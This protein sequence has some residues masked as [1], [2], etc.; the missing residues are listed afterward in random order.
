MPPASLI[1]PWQQNH[2]EEAERRIAACAAAREQ[3]LD[4]SPLELPFLPESIRALRWLIELQISSSQ[5]TELPAWFG[6]LSIL[7]TLGMEGCPVIDLPHGFNQSNSLRTIF[8][9][10]ESTW[11]LPRDATKK[12]ASVANIICNASKGRL[13]AWIRNHSNLIAFTI[14]GFEGALPHW[15]GEISNLERLSCTHGDLHSL[16]DSILQLKKLRSL[17]LSYNPRLGIPDELIKSYDPKKILDYYFRVKTQQASLPLNEFKLVL[18]GRGGVGK[19]SLVHKLVTGQFEE[20]V[21][22]PGVQITQ[23]QLALD[24]ELV[25]ARI[26]DFGGQ[27]ILHG[28]HRFFMTERAV[29][30][31]LLSGRDGHAEQDAHYWLSLIRSFAGEVPV[32][33]LLHRWAECRFQ[34][35]TQ[36]LRRTYGEGIHF[37]ETDSTT[38]YN[39]R[40]LQD[41]IKMLAQ[42]LPSLRARWPVEW[43]RVKAEL[44]TE[45]KNWLS[46]SDFCAFAAA[47]GVAVLDDQQALADCL[48][49]LGLMLSYRTDPVLRNCGVL[50]PQW[51]THAIYE[52]LNSPVVRTGGGELTLGTFSQVL[53]GDKSPRYPVALHPYLLAL[54]RKFLLCMPLDEHGKRYLIPDLLSIEEPALGD[55]FPEATALAFQYSY[56]SALPEGLLPRFIVETYVH[57]EPEYTWRRGVVLRRAG[58]RALV[59]GD[60]QARTVTVLVVGAARD[61]RRELLAIIREHFERIHRTYEQLAV[62]E[63]VPVVGA[64]RPVPYALLRKLE[65]TPSPLVQVEFADDVRLIQVKQLLDG[66]DLPNIPRPELFA[67]RR[68]DQYMST[69]ARPPL[70]FISY[71]EPDGTFFDQLR[72]HLVLQERQGKLRV[73][74]RALMQAGQD[75]DTETHIKL[76]E[77]HIVVPLLSS[78]YFSRPDCVEQELAYAMQRQEAGA[79]QVVPVLI[80]ACQLKRSA[81]GQLKALPSDGRPIS[82]HIDRDRA[83]LNVIEEL[84]RLLA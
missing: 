74:G 49:D 25:T 33:V 32:L 50:N 52:V 19:T 60:M 67:D 71:A 30:L 34:V 23:W 14:Y 40:A 20:F 21:Q 39:I 3:R 73:Y 44:P 22:T 45:K 27:E 82:Q 15:F 84:E 46:F 61:G 47:R 9:D 77:A 81:V 6:E 58:C 64:L 65:R 10:K 8:L 12:L 37:L 76:Q 26:W 31:V 28:T 13:P 18:V 2:L 75:A 83:W 51:A 69:A 62:T 16:P 54:M 68:G 17:S 5:I 79:C 56:T 41:T 59:R 72:Q 38:N 57:R 66:I 55:A 1:P 53:G 29:Y 63:M 78:D 11:N 43:R 70:L 24:G 35:S 42:Q 36:V 48:H 4:L 7:E 80:R